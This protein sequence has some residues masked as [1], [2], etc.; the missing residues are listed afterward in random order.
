MNLI[1]RHLDSADPLLL[2]PRETPYILKEV[3]EKL[4]CGCRDQIILDLGDCFLQFRVDANTDTLSAEFHATRFRVAKGFASVGEADPWNNYIGKE[5]GWTWLAQNQ[6][7]YLD[8]MLIGFDGI[9][10]NVLLQAIA[11]SVEAFTVSRVRKPTAAK[12]R[13][14]QRKA[15]K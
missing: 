13:N 3:F 14:S 9:E 12:A 15:Q 2:Q 1:A 7:G 6:Q 11:S 4:D 8:T 10:P 5:C